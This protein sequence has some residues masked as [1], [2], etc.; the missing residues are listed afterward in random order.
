MD[1]MFGTQ[2]RIFVRDL[3][4]GELVAYPASEWLGQYAA[5]I[6]GAIETWQQ[7]L[8]GTI[9]IT[10]TPEQGRVTV[11]DADRVIV[12]DEQW[13]AVAVDRD[14]IPISESAGDRL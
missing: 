13:W 5:V 9:A 3:I 4:G 10:G 8:G 6:N 7:S 11:N 14:G 1:E 12:L 2:L